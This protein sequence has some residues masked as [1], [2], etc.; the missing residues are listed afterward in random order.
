MPMPAL[1]PTAP[2]QMPRRVQHNMD[3]RLIIEDGAHYSYFERHVHG[4]QGGVEVIPHADISIGKHAS[5]KTEF[6]LI[7]GAVGRMPI[8]PPPL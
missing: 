3:A 6:E 2:F 1:R 5:F 4:P 7:K 8:F